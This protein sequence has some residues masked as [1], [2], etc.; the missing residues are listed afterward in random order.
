[1][2]RDPEPGRRTKSQVTIIDDHTA[3]IE[4]MTQVIDG[5][6]GYKVVGSAAA[7][8]PGLALCRKLQPEVIILDLVL[9]G[10][11]GLSLLGKLRLACPRSRIL[12]FTGCVNPSSVQGA[13]QAGA[14]GFMEKACT[15]EEL[16]AAV[17]AV[18]SG[19]ACF[20]T[21]ASAVIKNLVRRNPA[22]TARSD[23]LTAREKTVLGCLANGLSS[24]EI[25]ALLGVSVHTISNHRSR[26][27]KKTGLHRVAQLA[28]HA[29][30]CGLA[31]NTTGQL[32]SG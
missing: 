11:S 14:T 10:M 29:V 30:E 2:P 15:L 1:M 12:I 32:L 17:L 23:Q 6:P 24:K 31:C 27:M 3:I 7:A 16:R 8:I 22:A 20:G 19:R 28:L 5:L 26:L 13:V 25:A 18:G 9:P 21:Q 4:M